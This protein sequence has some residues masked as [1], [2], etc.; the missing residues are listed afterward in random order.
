M[1]RRVGQWSLVRGTPGWDG[2]WLCRG[3]AR[4]DQNAAFFI[5][6]QLLGIDEV[7]FQVFQLVVIH[8]ETPLEHPIRQALLP[9]Q[10]IKYLRQDRLIVHAT[11]PRARE[12]PLT[13]TLSQWER[14]KNACARLPPLVDRDGL[15]II[16]AHNPPVPIGLAAHHHNVNVLATEHWDQLLRQ[17][18]KL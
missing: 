6:R 12:K 7:F 1:C 4:P 13:L 10:E 11:P 18:L 14:G 5:R 2:G 9:L 3:V 8:P 17:G 16:A 15:L